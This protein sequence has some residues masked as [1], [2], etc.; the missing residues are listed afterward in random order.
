MDE[1]VS[2]QVVDFLASWERTGA[3]V[4]VLDLQPG[5]SYEQAYAAQFLSKPRQAGANGPI[6]GYQ[7]SLTSLAA[8]KFGA[9]DMPKPYVGTLQ[10]RNWHD[11]ALPLA[12]SGRNLMVECE[13]GFRLAT[14][15][16][17]PGVTTLEARQAVHSA[18]AAMEIVPYG[19]RLRN[20]SGQH[21][22]AIHN[23]GTH[24]A[25]GD[26]IGDGETDLSQLPV[27]LRGDGTLLAEAVTGDSGGDPFAVLAT[28]ANVVGAQ[29]LA[30]EPG[31]VIMTGSCTAPTP[32]AEGTRQIEVQFGPVLLAIDLVVDRQE[33]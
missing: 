22:I 24:I 27:I 2:A 31:M 12:A 4:D 20:R 21:M 23:F 33:D 26:Q 13:T 6:I 5:L 10:L 19:G 32:I 14:R 16:A 3:D 30:L 28:I 15:L 18:H 17:G 9:P 1:G 11:P 29:G 7:A 25:F 8:Q